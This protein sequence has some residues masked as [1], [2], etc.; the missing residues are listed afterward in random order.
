ME[1]TAKQISQLTGTSA[2]AVLKR[3]A[4]AGWPFEL[5]QGRGRPQKVFRV[6]DLPAPIQNKYNRSLVGG[7]ARGPAPT[8]AGQTHRSAPT[9]APA[10]SAG[11]MAVASAKADLLRLYLNAVQSAGWGNKARARER[12]MLAYNSGVAWPELFSTIGKTSWKTIEGWKL[13]AANEG[14]EA[15]A[16]HRGVWR[17]GERIVT[18]E[19]G[20]I[21]LSCA[22]HPNRP[23]KAEAI[24]MAKAV[25]HAKGIDN[26]HCRS[27]Y[28]R[29][30][31]DWIDENHDMWVF[32]RQGAKAWNDKC[33]FFIE[34]NLD[35]I[36][37]GDVLVA[38]GHVLNFEI[39]NPW[40]G[41]P[42]RMILILWLDMRSNFPLGWEIMPTENTQAIAAAL[43]RAILRL[44]KMP[45]VAYLDNG[46]AFRS[47]FFKGCDNFDEAGFAGVFEQ[48]G[49]KT[50][51]AWPYHGQSKTVE[52]FFKTF[53][54]LERWCPTYTGTSIEKKP[55]RMMRGERIH[56]AVHEKI[57]SGRVLTL[58]QAHRAIASWFDFYAARPQRG[59]LKGAAPVDLYMEGR[60]EGVNPAELTYL[61]MRQEIRH[62]RRSVIR[63]NGRRYYHPEL[64]GRRHPVVIRYD[65]QDPGAVYVFDE[66]KNAL[67]CTATEVET[68]HP[69]ANILG[70]EADRQALEDQIRIKKA[71]EDAASASTR[72]FLEETVM[73]EHRRQMAVL[74]VDGGADKVK[75]LPLAQK[76]ITA[77]DEE[78]I[79]KQVDQYFE[80]EKTDDFWSGLGDLSEMDRYE[81][82]LEAEA[83]ELLIP[84][85]HSAFMAYFEQTAQYAALERDGYWDEARAHA[86]VMYQAAEG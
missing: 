1:L 84:K 79:N 69:A 62:V 8:P 30:L 7:Q 80:E 12:F 67:L 20:E 6:E 75:P 18:D 81:K 72:A 47:R 68:I 16:D 17:K 31:S 74:G 4:S 82:L 55:P 14:V 10:L 48:L 61:M 35:L 21:L 32:S 40:T 65:F 70:T 28:M 64:A 25:M 85:E 19:Q 2:R 24:R 51:F 76:Q 66:R 5:V 23:M 34:R 42:K 41:K 38:D 22:L 53:G 39:L 33:A 86:A 71:Q 36:N 49:I 54:E 43:R 26:G 15:L 50:I 27:T 44:G 11:Q 3:A 13:Q 52:R 37:A 78:A 57:M 60:G 58:E 45:K 59:H 73:P 63:F 29:W 9:W 83:R 56:R 46:K 77:V